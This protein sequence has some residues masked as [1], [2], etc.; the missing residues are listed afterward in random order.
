MT[1]DSSDNN[2]SSPARVNR[3]QVSTPRSTISKPSNMDRVIG[4]S[5][6]ATTNS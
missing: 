3:S 5:V 2:S 4:P 1:E 6:P